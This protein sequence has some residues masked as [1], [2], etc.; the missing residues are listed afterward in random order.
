V[1]SVQNNQKSQSIDS[2]CKNSLSAT[3]GSGKEER[4]KSNNKGG[5]KQQQVKEQTKKQEV[6][7]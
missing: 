2:E 3:G 5:N 1:F 7:G 6:Q 4:D